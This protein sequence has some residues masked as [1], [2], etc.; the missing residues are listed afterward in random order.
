MANKPYNK[1][2]FLGGGVCSGV[3]W[4]AMI[5]IFVNGQ[6]YAIVQDPENAGTKTSR[7][8]ILGGG[9]K[10]FLFS[11]LLEEDAHFDWYFSRGWNH[12]LVSHFYLTIPHWKFTTVAKVN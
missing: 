2:L 1:A 10:Y 4:L 12:Q 7:H 5:Y 9:F 11:P 8:P 6:T 3:G